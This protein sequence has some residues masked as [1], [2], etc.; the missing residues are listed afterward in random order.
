LIGGSRAQDTAGIARV[1]EMDLAS[2]EV[3]RMVVSELALYAIEIA[4]GVFVWGG[5]STATSLFEV[6]A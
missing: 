1:P 6:P 2:I 3:W 4:F 5:R